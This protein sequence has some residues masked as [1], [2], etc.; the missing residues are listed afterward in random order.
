MFIGTNLLSTEILNDVLTM[1]ADSQLPND[2]PPIHPT[3]STI[4]KKQTTL[5]TTALV[6]Y[7]SADVFK[8]RLLPN[9][10]SLE[11]NFER[12]DDHVQ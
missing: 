3:T 6:L 5:F 8:L 7:P 9:G 2:P 4:H 1:I 11:R 12:M 10:K